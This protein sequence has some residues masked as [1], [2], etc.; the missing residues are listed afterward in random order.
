MGVERR[1]DSIADRPVDDFL[2]MIGRS[3]QKRQGK[4]VEFG[5]DLADFND[6]DAVDVD[7]T[8]QRLLDGVAFIAQLA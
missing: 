2:Q 6:V 5:D 1:Q 4:H 8:R 7:D 3:K